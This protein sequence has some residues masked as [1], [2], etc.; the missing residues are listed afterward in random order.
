VKKNKLSVIDAIGA[1]FNAKPFI[2]FID[3]V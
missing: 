3:T 2:P 1:V